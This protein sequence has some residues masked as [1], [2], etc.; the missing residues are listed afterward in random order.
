MN[1]SVY[2]E[3]IDKKTVNGWQYFLSE[4]IVAL[5]DTGMDF[6]SASNALKT[7]WRSMSTEE[8][9]HYNDLGRIGIEITP[10]EKCEKTFSSIKKKREHDCENTTCQ[11]CNKT[12]SSY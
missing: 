8:R 3:P 11:T 2:L 1:V 9:K 5:K 12:F 10:C 6:G 7:E 4:R